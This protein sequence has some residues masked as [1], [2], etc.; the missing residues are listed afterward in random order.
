MISE[1]RFKNKSTPANETT[2]PPKPSVETPRW[3]E[4]SRAASLW[5]FLTKR[6][7]N[8][9]PKLPLPRPGGA[10]LCTC[11]VWVRGFSG[12][13]G[14]HPGCTWWQPCLAGAK[15]ADLV[16]CGGAGW[17]SFG[18]VAGLWNSGSSVLATPPWAPSPCGRAQG[19]T[20]APGRAD[21]EK[22]PLLGVWQRSLG[23][24][25]SASGWYCLRRMCQAR[26]QTADTVLNWWTTFLGMK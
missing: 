1:P 12:V 22:D 8:K 25:S 13:G 16:G 19:A 18:G 9:P 5:S 7:K 15:W 11:A 17:G 20:L 14:R 26:L 3:R 2:V 21:G 24:C 6:A 10:H 4:G 23:R